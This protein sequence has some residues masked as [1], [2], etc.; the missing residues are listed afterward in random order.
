MALLAAAALPARAESPVQFDAVLTSDVMTLARGGVDGGTTVMHNLDLTA[1]WQG[2]NG[3]EAFGYILA[4]GGG[5]FSADRVGDVQV[6]SNIEAPE[7]VRLFEAWAKKS[8][9][10]GSVTFGLIDLNGIF[11]VQEVGGLFIH[12]SHG[13]GPDY[14]QTGPSIFPFS[15]LGVVGEWKATDQLTLRAGV[16]DGVPGDPTR[17][18]RFLAI[19][20]SAQ[21]GAHIVAEAQQDF[22]GGY[23]K[24]GVW[25]NTAELD[26]LDGSG[27]KREKFGAYGQ[28]AATLVREGDG[29]QGLK[30][31]LRFGTAC[32][33]VLLLDSYAGGGLVYTGLLPGRDGDQVGF[34]VARAHFGE[35]ARA[36]DPGQGAAE[37]NYEVSYRVQIKDGFAVQPMMQYVQHPGGR[38]DIDDAVVVGLRFEVG[39]GAF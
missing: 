4:D 31:W 20:L 12:P 34:A 26:L 23:V 25:S 11:D 6:T 37:T 35:P 14:A 39:L 2:E 10:H 16:F 13:I 1:A 5:A 30:G 21:E 19:K 38:D 24:A 7:G 15:G 29:E 36:A 8:G 3:W 27:R 9:E 22:D 17:P 33:D 32:E 18:S 28:I